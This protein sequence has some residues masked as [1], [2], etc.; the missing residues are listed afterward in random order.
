MTSRES[1]E[2]SSPLRD[3]QLIARGEFAPFFAAANSVAAVLMVMILFGHV[4]TPYLVGWAAAVVAVNL[5]AM[6]LARTQAVTHVGRSMPSGVK[7]R[8]WR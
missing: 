3:A 6:Q 2:G 7:R 1:D 4:A 5:G 8:G